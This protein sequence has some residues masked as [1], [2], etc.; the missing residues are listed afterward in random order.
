MGNLSIFYL[1]DNQDALDVFRATFGKA[2]DVRITSSLDEALHM[3][4]SGPADI[5]ISDQRMPEMIG[6]EFLRRAHELCPKSLRILLTGE[7]K[8]GDM[9]DEIKEGVVEFFIQKPWD[10]AEMRTMLERAGMAYELRQK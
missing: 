6:T 7:A 2:Y 9:L 4:S 8:L 10:P 1:D 5:I 3:L